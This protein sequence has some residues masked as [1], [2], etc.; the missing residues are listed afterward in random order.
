MLE[1]LTYKMFFYSYHHAV[2]DITSL[3]Y[4]IANKLSCTCI[5]CA[6]VIGMAGGVVTDQANADEDMS[7][8][9][10]LALA[11][12]S[13]LT[14]GGGV[15]GDLTGVDI[16]ADVLDVAGKIYIASLVM[17]EEDALGLVGISN[18]CGPNVSFIHR[19]KDTVGSAIL[20]LW[21]I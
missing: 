10:R 11:G 15:V 19:R 20:S 6:A 3:R 12:G 1:C 2:V 17:V 14:E 18:S 13:V 7:L 9:Q 21:V 4:I 16:A 5:I 8:E